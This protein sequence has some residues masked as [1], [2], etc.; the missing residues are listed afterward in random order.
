[1]SQVDFE[2]QKKTAHLDVHKMLVKSK[3][4]SPKCCLCFQ[5]VHGDLIEEKGLGFIS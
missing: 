4:H 3:T 5:V 2:I 1:M